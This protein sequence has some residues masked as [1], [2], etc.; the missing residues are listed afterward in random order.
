MIELFSVPWSQVE[1]EHVRAF[2]D[3]A[4]ATDDEEG[5]TWEAKADDERGR[6]RPDSIRKAACGLANQIGGYLII[7]ARRDK[8]TGEWSLPGIAAPEE[9]PKL[10]TGKVLRRLQP[11]PRFD[12]KRWTLDDGRVVLV[13][14]IEPVAEPPCMTP[15]GRVYERVSGE[16]LPVEDPA[17]LDRLFR[18]GDHARGRAERF[19]R[20]A[21]R[22]AMKAPRWKDE[23]SV[24][25]ALALAAVGREK[26]DISSRLFVEA[27][28]DAITQST[29]AF[30]GNITPDDIEVWQQ[31]DAYAVLGQFD[32]HVLLAT[33]E[34]KRHVRHTWLV[35]ATWD[36]TVAASATFN[37]NCVESLTPFD[38]IVR[39]GWR[40]VAALV[41]R[42]GG[43]GPGHLAVVIAATQAGPLTLGDVEG[44]R[45]PTAP[46]PGT[47]YAAL[48]KAT[49]MGRTV[50]VG[51]PSDDV[52]DSLGRELHRAAGY[53]HDEPASQ[54]ELG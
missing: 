43:Y 8:A 30:W 14:Q 37:R 36:G 6:L 13:V 47:L 46:P 4:A 50:S 18:R 9:E 17:L 22:R 28:R 31:Q 16:T 7:G 29:W 53:F 26:D 27:T 25:I 12:P 19:A 48:P 15:Q 3:D 49:W 35:Q 1:L 2:L 45:P 11:V 10:W 32:R 24:G 54:P 44:E 34:E 20:R 41:E 42:L 33:G 38:E 51:E 40:E 52:I 21:A 23:R 39:R 5:V